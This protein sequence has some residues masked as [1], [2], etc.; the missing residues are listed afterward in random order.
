MHSLHVP[1]PVTHKYM[2]HAINILYVGT[3][4]VVSLLFLA[5]E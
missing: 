3:Q 5:Q 4:P 1:V 2:D